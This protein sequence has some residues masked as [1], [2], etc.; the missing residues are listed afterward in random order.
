MLGCGVRLWGHAG[1]C[2]A[3]VGVLWM[4]LNQ[5][6]QMHL[7]AELLRTCLVGP[8]W[9]YVQPKLNPDARDPLLRVEIWAQSVNLEPMLIID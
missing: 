7:A 9:G 3:C 2:W 1:P 6:Y 4:V 5:V 8:S